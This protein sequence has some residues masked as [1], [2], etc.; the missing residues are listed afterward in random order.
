MVDEVC[1][2][3]GYPKTS[4]T[5]GM[6]LRRK[7]GTLVAEAGVGEDQGKGL[8]ILR[9]CPQAARLLCLATPSVSF[10]ASS[11]PEGAFWA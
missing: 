11:L 2:T 10:A 1:Q 4:H 9:L 7:A 6:A 5:G 8:P 3:Q